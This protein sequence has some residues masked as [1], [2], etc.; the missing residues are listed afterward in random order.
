LRESDG[1]Q[2]IAE[3]PARVVA[4]A[5][6]LL[7]CAAHVVAGGIRS[8][9]SFRMIHAALGGW[10]RN[11]V[12]TTHAFGLVRVESAIAIATMEAA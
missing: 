12:S 10:T 2:R 4:W 5:R 6:N 7:A 3:I 9:A 11:V 8:A 1:E